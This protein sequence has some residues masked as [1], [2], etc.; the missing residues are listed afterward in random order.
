M[1]L[2]LALCVLFARFSFADGKEGKPAAVHM[3]RL[4][5]LALQIADD[6]L[7]ALECPLLESLN[8]QGRRVQLSSLRFLAACPVLQHVTLS[9]Q[10]WLGDAL[11]LDA[12]HAAGRTLQSLAVDTSPLVTVGLIR[13]VA[14]VDGGKETAK[15]GGAAPAPKISGDQKAEAAA[16]TR[17][18]AKA[19][20]SSRGDRKSVA[21]H[22]DSSGQNARCA[23]SLPVLDTFA[24]DGCS[25]TSQEL[26]LELCSRFVEA[27]PSLNTWQLG[28]ASDELVGQ[29]SEAFAHRNLTV[30]S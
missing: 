14:G 5:M 29:L 20:A 16:A 11:L 24:I 28:G 25:M 26:T 15:D 19:A 30:L 10:S 21:E 13:A 9:A 1:L 4:H 22:K 3:A 6:A 12:M 18:S 8:L 27:C 7:N 2:T 23:P 17:S